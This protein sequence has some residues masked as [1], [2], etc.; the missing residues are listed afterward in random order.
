[1]KFRVEIHE[2]SG[3][4]EETR[5]MGAAQT[6]EE[7]LRNALQSLVSYRAGI[8][9]VAPAQ[10]V[11]EGPEVTRNRFLVGMLGADIVAVLLG[12]RLSVTDAQ[13]LGVWLCAL[14]FER[15]EEAAAA[16]TAACDT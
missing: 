7:A 12:L 14:A 2:D 11:Q 16:I 15:P 9:A 4:P 13:S 5:H 3:K 10:G 8:P 6:F 1:M